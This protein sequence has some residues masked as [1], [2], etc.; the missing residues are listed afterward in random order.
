MLDVNAESF[1]LRQRF[2]GA[3]E[4]I[5]R[6]LVQTTVDDVRWISQNPRGGLSLSYAPLDVG[7]I[8]DEK[9]FSQN[10]STV[11]TSATIS[12]GR[13][14][15]YFKGRLGLNHAESILLDESFDYR[16]AAAVFIP[17]DMPDMDTLE[18]DNSLG[19]AVIDLVEASQ[20]HALMLFTSHAALRRVHKA[21]APSLQELGFDVLAQGIDGRPGQLV[22]IFRESEKTLLLGTGTF[23][24]GIDFAGDTLQLLMMARLPF[25]VP[26]D[27]IFAARSEIYEDAFNEMAIPESILRF[28]QGFGR[29]IR[30]NKDHGA[31]VL[32]DNRLLNR[33][34]GQLFLDALP[35]T[36]I[37]MPSLDDLP[38]L[39]G[40]WLHDFT[41]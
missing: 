25:R 33:P 31:V 39:V 23:W 41:D 30:T 15:D 17:R 9:V 7:P 8:L 37:Q 32:F 19:N 5:R 16:D 6:V 36:N 3:Q 14:F 34:Y 29:L 40:G 26:N 18:Y 11:F 1:S 20:G 2:M 4:I 22:T 13:T 21:V 24:E 35:E 10:K 28:R 27:P 12:L 38:D